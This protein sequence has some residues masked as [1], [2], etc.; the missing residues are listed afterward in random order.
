MITS[1]KTKTSSVPSSIDDR[2][3]DT[4]ITIRISGEKS[5][6]EYYKIAEMFEG[7]HDPTKQ[8]DS[9]TFEKPPHCLVWTN[10]SLRIEKD[11][12]LLLHDLCGSARAGRV[13]ALMGPSGAGKTTLLNALGNRVPYGIL[14][15]EITF[16]Q[17]PFVT[18]DL[19]FVPQ[20]DEVNSNLTV[21]EQ[22]ELVGL[23]KCR[24]RRDMYTR[25][26]IVINVLGLH[27][28]AQ[29]LCRDLTGGELKKV[30]VGMGMISKPN[31]LFLDEPT[32]G[33]DSTAAYYIV[34]HLVELAESLNIAVI[35]TIHQPA[36]MVLD[37][38]QDLYLLGNG[39]IVYT[40]PL[41]CSERYFHSIGYLRSDGVGFTDFLLDLVSKPPADHPE[42]SWQKL[43]LESK[44]CV[45]YAQE[46]GALNLAVAPALSASPAPP[47]SRRL[48]QIIAFF[49]KYYSRDPGFYLRRI[50]SLIVIAFFSGTLFFRLTP[51][52]I[53]ASKYSGA[54]F[55][56][57][58]AVLF[59]AVA[60]TGLLARD[61][62]QAVEQVKNAVVCPAIYCFAQLL[63]SLPFNFIAALI[64]QSVFHWLSRINPNWESFLYA[65]L[66]T[67]GHLLLMEAYMLSAVEVLENA[68][69]CVTF[70]MI[71]LGYLFLF[72]GFF[73]KVE[74]MPRWISWVSY[75][76]PTKYSFDGYLHV[77][78]K[79]QIFLE[80]GSSPPT[81]IRG[82][83][84]LKHQYNRKGC[85]AWVMFGVLLA[86][87]VALRLLHYGIFTYH[88]LPFLPS[89][90]DYSIEVSDDDDKSTSS[91]AYDLGVSPD[92][93]DDDERDTEIGATR[94]A[95][96]R[97][98]E[99]EIHITD[100]R[101]L[102]WR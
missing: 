3:R 14:T 87:V 25:L 6:Y 46:Q 67:W 94:R 75:L 26:D 17:R 84:L 27:D 64:F 7:E 36:E 47:A 74:E 21:Q 4:I 69:L 51:E 39:R 18:S 86:W 93:L 70:A 44:F 53:Y 62:R 35:L 77:I 90:D 38:L 88:V 1:Y 73:V 5:Q 28:K 61:R 92:A 16:G 99:E 97:V 57:T 56:N 10:L 30:S 12:T 68:M 63:V 15:G 2:E 20:V 42:S 89:H 82:D 98:Y 11:D 40:G 95:E 41:S 32:T 55:F 54:A 22:I 33:L 72:A 76:A 100:S 81:Y 37:L 101:K 13:L 52:T 59:S 19:Y 91:E 80:S 31:V 29:C 66:I 8:M 65:V 43:Y 78:F 45:N 49:V 23:L 24:N 85:K 48:Y 34:K 60:A 102:Q 71:I 58:W 96:S 79:D 83:D 9:F 50:L